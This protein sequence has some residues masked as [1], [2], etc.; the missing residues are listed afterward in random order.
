M[1]HNIKSLTK[2][3]VNDSAFCHAAAN[4][5]DTEHLQT[6]LFCA[7]GTKVG[8]GRHTMCIYIYTYTNI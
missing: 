4:Q 3:T 1:W 8:P 2:S 7:K 6:N 5:V